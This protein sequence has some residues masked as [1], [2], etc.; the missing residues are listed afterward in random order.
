MRRE[1]GILFYFQSNKNRGSAK[2]SI[3]E[4]IWGNDVNTHNNFDL[5][6]THVK[7]LQV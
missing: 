4:Y 3:A 5:V 7:K 2:E 6:Y 1:F